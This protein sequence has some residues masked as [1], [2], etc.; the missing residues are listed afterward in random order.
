MDKFIS[1]FKHSASLTPEWLQDFVDGF[2]CTIHNNK[3]LRFPKSKACGLG[4][5]IEISPDV[6]VLLVD[7]VLNKPIRFTR[8]P[9]E[10]DFW[11]VYYDM[12]D[13]ISKHIV[14]DVN[15]D[16]GYKS[17]MGFAIIDSHLKSTYVSQVG[18]RTYSLRLYIRKSFI[19]RYIA[20]TVMEKD[21]N[22]VF[23]HKKNRMFYYGHIDSRSKVAL[24]NL[25]QQKIDAIN[26]EFLLRGTVYKLFGYFIER[27][28]SNT[29]NTG[30]FLEKDLKAIMIS[31]EYLLSD[32]SKPFPGLKLLSEIA[33]MSLTKYRNLYKNIFGITPALLFK[34][35]KLI[36]AKDLLESG[37]FNLISDV[38]YELG[39]YKTSYFSLLYK[40]YHGHL[41]NAVFKAKLI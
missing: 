27:L 33:N 10:D 36:L 2:G 1:E 24:Y 38:A 3:L 7:M 20:D 34:N 29:P 11:I 22:K 9:S 40:E 15:H 16:I 28:N 25:K 39:Y 4:Y 14:D 18:E 5:F 8:M 32:L 23:N 37:D 12:S 6:S 35:E 31:Q 41:P 19:K 26:Y 13:K 30:I 17:K 21:L